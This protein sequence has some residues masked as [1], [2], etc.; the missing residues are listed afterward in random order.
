M[1]IDQ[2][3]GK[4]LGGGP[5]G[6]EKAA[7][8]TWK[9]EAEENIKALEDIRK[10][11]AMS[12]ELKDY[13]DF[14]ADAAWEQMSS[15]TDSSQASNTEKV[16]PS[17]EESTKQEAQVR[18]I[19]R[20]TKIAAAVAMLLA[21][22]F[23]WNNY[24]SSTTS[25]EVNEFATLLDETQ[26]VD[27]EDGTSILL[28]ERTKLRSKGDRSVSLKGRAYFDVAKSDKD[29]FTVNI[30]QGTITVLGTQFTVV[31]DDKGTE[32]Y[33]Q[34]GSVKYT[35]KGKDYILRPGQ[36]L[37]LIDGTVGIVEAKDRNYA[38]WKDKK[39]TFTDSSMQEVADVLS[40]HYGEVVELKDPA[41]FKDCNVVGQWNDVTLKELLGELQ[42]IFGL[43]YAIFSSMK[44]S[45]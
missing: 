25:G 13:H 10:I 1:N 43:E 29:N 11:A 15:I 33:L 42:G 38:S 6:E 12:E 34:E 41:L 20:W 31:A 24:G 2:I 19:Q 39:I 45:P 36:L 9:K 8:E 14:D 17:V 37:K 32:V 18:S 22:T 5:S 28:D 4:V 44:K 3:I 27:L 21:A 40:R 30:P 16:E 35:F 7:L 23:A 26:K